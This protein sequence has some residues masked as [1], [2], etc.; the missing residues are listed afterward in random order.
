MLYNN[1]YMH[2]IYT[3]VNTNQY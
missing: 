3:S 2:I 1:N